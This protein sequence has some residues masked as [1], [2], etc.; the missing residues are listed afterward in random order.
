VI[1]I[2]ID[3]GTKCGWAVRTP[4]QMASGVWLLKPK[5]GAVVGAR[6]GTLFW[7]LHNLITTWRLARAGDEVV[8][9][10]EDVRAHAGTTAA[11]VYGALVGV[12]EL[13]CGSFE[14]PIRLVPIG[15]GTV[16][17]F[18]THNGGAS[19]A[20]MLYAAEQQWAGVMFDSDDEVDARWIAECAWRK[21]E[22]ERG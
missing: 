16:K 3:P 8:V 4:D 15:V 12:I 5:K 14:P 17:K 7:N 22:D 11:H 13:I 9:A 6:L 2:G 20:A 10:Y 21:L 1:V 19:K 18:A